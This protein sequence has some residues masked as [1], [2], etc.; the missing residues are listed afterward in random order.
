MA[1]ES[2]G[3][4]MTA[5]TV[6]KIGNAPVAP[7]LQPPVLLTPDN[8]ELEYVCHKLKDQFGRGGLTVYFRVCNFGQMTLA[9]HY[10]VTLLKSKNRFSVGP[11]SDLVR[12]F[13]V[14]FPNR[15]IQRLD[16][17][18]LFWLKGKRVLGSVRT[19][20]KSYDQKSLP[21]EVQYSVIRELL[22]CY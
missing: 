2:G 4:V 9:R 11:G 7:H 19:V 5:S 3:V 14:L 6:T 17:I 18:E 8:Y 20:T 1:A 12:H 21:D 15:R 13:R 22:R 16:R 10:K